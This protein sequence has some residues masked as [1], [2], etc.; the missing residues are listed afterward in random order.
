[1]RKNDLFEEK[2]L[3]RII[4]I[5]CQGDECFQHLVCKCFPTFSRYMALLL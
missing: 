5:F 1:M 4:I 2:K 3:K